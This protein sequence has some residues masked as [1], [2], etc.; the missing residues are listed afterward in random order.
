MC[1]FPLFFLLGPMNMSPYTVANHQQV[2]SFG[3]A[4]NNVTSPSETT[5]Y[6]PGY[7]LGGPNSPSVRT[8][9]S[10]SLAL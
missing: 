3:P 1:L 2:L 6:L 9:V 5:G 7:L 8:A 4:T 10:I